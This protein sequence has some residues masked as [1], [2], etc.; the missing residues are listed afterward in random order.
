M[1]RDELNKKYVWTEAKP[2]AQ[3]FRS[4]VSALCIALKAGEMMLLLSH[5]ID[6]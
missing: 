2:Y 1:S 6:A 5:G 4:S 3:K